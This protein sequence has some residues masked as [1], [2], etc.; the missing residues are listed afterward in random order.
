VR[1]AS[2]FLSDIEVPSPA[3]DTPAY[4]HFARLGFR[5]PYVRTHFARL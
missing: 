5:R 4:Q 2:G 1:G 3:L